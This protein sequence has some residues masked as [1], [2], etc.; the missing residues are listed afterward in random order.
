MHV[1]TLEEVS[2]AQPYK[3]LINLHNIRLAG[4]LHHYQCRTSKRVHIVLELRVVA[5]LSRH[6]W[7]LQQSRKQNG[8]LA[9]LGT[10]CE[11]LGESSFA[12]NPFFA[13]ML[14]L[15]CRGDNCLF[16]DHVHLLDSIQLIHKTLY[17]TSYLPARREA[18]L[19]KSP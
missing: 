10:S 19:R 5:R 18:R 15:T 14:D 1:G 12:P 13:R 8:V 4:L 7:N 17:T 11:L 6:T 2:L 16:Q 3:R 9:S